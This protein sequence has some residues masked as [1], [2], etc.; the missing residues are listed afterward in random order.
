M[1][2]ARVARKRKKEKKC[3]SHHQM[4]WKDGNFRKVWHEKRAT[5]CTHDTSKIKK[6]TM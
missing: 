5:L 2:N 4:K 6:T 3:I 1:R